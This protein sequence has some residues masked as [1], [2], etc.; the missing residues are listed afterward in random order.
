[1]WILVCAKSKVQRFLQQFWK[2]FVGWLVTLVPERPRRWIFFHCKITAKSPE[3]LV[4]ESFKVVNSV[5]FAKENH[6]SVDLC[7]WKVQATQTRGIGQ[8]HSISV[9]L[10]LW[11]VQENQIRGIGQSH[12]ISVDLCLCQMQAPQIG[13]RIKKI[14]FKEKKSY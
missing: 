14:L 4:L 11:E 3:T 9:D 1:M 10:C 6:I 5:R 2:F 12:Q 7:L 13:S 8:S